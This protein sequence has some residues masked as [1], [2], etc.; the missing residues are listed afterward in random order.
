MDIKNQFVP[1]VPRGVT[2]GDAEKPGTTTFAPMPAPP[3]DKQG[4]AH[5]HP[6]SHGA[7][8]IT[9]QREGGQ[10]TRICIECACGQRIELDCVY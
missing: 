6:A 5:P 2:L 4:N 3:P 7:P 8:Q 10:V 1:F 9:L